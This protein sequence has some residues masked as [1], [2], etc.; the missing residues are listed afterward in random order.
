[1]T[2]FWLCCVSEHIK[3]TNRKIST[4]CLIKLNE[5]RFKRPAPFKRNLRILCF[6]VEHIELGPIFK[7]LFS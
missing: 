2:Q 6:N 1:M 3:H 7:R 5:T 4:H